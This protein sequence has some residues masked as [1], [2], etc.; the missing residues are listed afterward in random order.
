MTNYFI[1]QGFDPAHFSSKYHL[2]E[3]IY[4]Y[5]LPAYSFTLPSHSLYFTFC[6]KPVIQFIYYFCQMQFR[7]FIC[8][9]SFYIDEEEKCIIVNY[10]RSEMSC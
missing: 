1:P 3:P 4:I 6:V 7:I 10:R 5:Y 8:E 2:I 9:C